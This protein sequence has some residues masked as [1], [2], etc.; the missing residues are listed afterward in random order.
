MSTL[1]RNKEIPILR[2][3]NVS[4]KYVLNK[5]QSLL[6]LKDINF[7]LH[8]GQFISLMGPSGSGKSTLICIAGC[9]DFPS[10]GTFQFMGKNL[11][12]DDWR[13]RQILRKEHIS[14][15]FQHYNLMA[16]LSA[17]ENI[18]YPLAVKGIKKSKRAYLIQENLDK[19]G[20]GDLAK[21][22]PH[23]LSGGQQQRVSIARALSLEPKLLIAD[24]PTAALDKK[25]A[26]LVLNLLRDVSKTGVAVLMGTHDARMAKQTDRI[27]NLQDGCIVSQG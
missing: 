3:I 4:K 8:S 21:K 13:K 10:E 5:N 18:E 14:V 2:L 25:N 23:E 12:P 27:V 1:E 26:I 24:E 16:H 7:D 6:A 20:I 17:Y 9:L 22:K 11:A 19:L 15:I